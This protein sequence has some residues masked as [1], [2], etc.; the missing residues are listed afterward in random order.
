MYLENNRTR[1]SPVRL[2]LAWAAVISVMVLIFILSHQSQSVSGLF[3]TRIADYAQQRVK[4]STAGTMLTA[5]FARM[6]IYGSLYLILSL[7]LA[8]ALSRSGVHHVKNGMLVLLI[9]GLFAV[10]D[11]LHQ[12]LVPGRVSRLSD[13]LVAL[14]GILTGIILYQIGSLLHDI[15]TERSVRRDEAPRL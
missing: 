4:F 3:F 7:L 11:E 13:I 14:G 15:G 9:S 6:T 5:D 1:H 2:L 12:F 10:S 8:G